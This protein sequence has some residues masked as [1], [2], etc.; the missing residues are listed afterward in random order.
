M[1]E[2]L[3]IPLILLLYVR[4]WKYKMLIDDHV[5]RNG[6][7]LNLTE[8]PEH[9]SFYEKQ[10]PLLATVTNIGVFIFSCVA[11][12]ALFGWKVALL[13]A[14]MP[15][16]V[17]GTAWNTG[18][19]YQTTAFLVLVSYYFASMGTFFGLFSGM[20]FY[21][22]AL[23]STVSAI[24]F[25]FVF[26]L[27][28]Q[29][30]A[31]WIMFIPLFFFLFGHRF[32]T[33]LRLRQEKHDR[34]MIQTG[35]IRASKFFVMNKVLAYYTV[36]NLWPS[37]LGFF[38]EFGKDE[39][40]ANKREKPTRL[41]WL[42]LTLNILFAYWSY[43]VNPLGMLWYYGFLMIFSQFTTFG[44][45]VAERYLYLSNIGFCIIIESFIFSFGINITTCVIYAIICALWAYRAHIYIKSY[46]DNA[47][48]LI[49]SIEAFPNAPENYNN[50]GSHY[51]ERGRFLKAIEPLLMAS[52]F[53]HNFSSRINANLSVCYLRLGQFDKARLYT[54]KALENCGIDDVEPLRRQL[55]ELDRRI[56]MMQENKRYL[57]KKG[58]I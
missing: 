44:Q 48:L 5:P 8:R 31:W 18:N 47:S 34:R 3:Y 45:F 49:Q 30:P 22:A 23:G 10:R 35:E 6:M 17:S 26:P 52:R 29:G 39:E 51:M 15:S 19:Y 37:R 4:T 25:A 54:L 38:H 11:I 14:V 50:L 21:V 36:L 58:I 40:N 28:Y 27:I 2:Y 7:L 9:W 33:G 41:F 32:Q 55:G 53:V 46:K 42:S 56:K 13:Y 20:W 57:K 43:S 12:H 24:P 1:I 16:Q